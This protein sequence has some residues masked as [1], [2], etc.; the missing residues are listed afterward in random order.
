V[1]GMQLVHMN[2]VWGFF[3]MKEYSCSLTIVTM[4]I[5]AAFPVTFWSF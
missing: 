3:W 1:K 4:G 5:Q 2:H